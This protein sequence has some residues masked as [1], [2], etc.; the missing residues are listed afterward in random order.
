MAAVPPAQGGMQIL[1]TLA[2]IVHGFVTNWNDME[3]I[4]HYT[5][6]NECRVAPEENPVL[7]TEVPLNP[8]PYRERMTQVMFVIFNVPATYVATQAVLYL[9]VSGRT[10]GL[11][12]DSGDGVLHTMPS[13]ASYALPHA[14]L[15]WDLA[16]CD[17]TV[18][19]MKILI[20]RG[21]SFTTTAER[22]IVRDVKEKLC[23]TAS[24]YDTELKSTAKYCTKCD[25]DIRKNLYVNVVLSSGTTISRGIVECMRNELTTLAP[26]TMKTK[27]ELPDGN[28]STVG[29]ERFRC[30]DVLF[31]SRA[32]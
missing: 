4:L 22:K 1:G 14:I 30:V 18:Y 6:Y 31:L 16:G 13:Y 23:C 24:D 19:L 21:Y 3:K 7:L 2:L 17:L 25:A 27:D 26:S 12:M 5:F 11:M 32:T 8:K 29:A 10:T 20:E 15:H 28:I 9:H